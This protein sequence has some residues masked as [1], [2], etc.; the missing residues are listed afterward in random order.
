MSL[1]INITNRFLANDIYQMDAFWFRNIS[2]SHDITYPSE[3]IYS[4]FEIDRFMRNL[5]LNA[6]LLISRL[7]Y[8]KSFA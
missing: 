3:V 7:R 5:L 8:I 6:G 4:E 2:I 1:Q